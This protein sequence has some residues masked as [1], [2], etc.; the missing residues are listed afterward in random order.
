[1]ANEFPE[2]CEGEGIAKNLAQLRITDEAFDEACLKTL[3][4]HLAAISD[5]KHVKSASE[6]APLEIGRDR[7]AL[8]LRATVEGTRIIM[9]DVL[10][11]PP[12]L[13]PAERQARQLAA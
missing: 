6:F 2:I 9:T 13:A 12:S 10:D 11:K 8:G 3:P 4:T 5:A 1:M 7:S